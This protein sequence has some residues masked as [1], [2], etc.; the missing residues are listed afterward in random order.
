MLVIT[1][2]N[3]SCASGFLNP[4]EDEGE[5]VIDQFN[6]E[7]GNLPPALFIYPLVTGVTVI[8]EH[9]HIRQF[10]LIQPVEAYLFSMLYSLFDTFTIY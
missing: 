3:L 2:E 5:L 1:R 8:I 9:H 6:A 4:H 7:A 10:A